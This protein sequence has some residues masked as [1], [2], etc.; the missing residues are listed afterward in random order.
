EFSDASD[1]FECPGGASKQHGGVVAT[2]LR[3]LRSNQLEPVVFHLN[4]DKSD[5]AFYRR[6]M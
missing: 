5:T 4:P 3:S 1:W 6:T 2:F